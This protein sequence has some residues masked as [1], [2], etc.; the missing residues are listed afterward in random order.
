MRAEVLN[1][2][3]HHVNQYAEQKGQAHEH[4]SPVPCA[5]VAATAGPSVP[6]PRQAGEQSQ[7]RHAAS[8]P[9]RDFELN[10]RQLQMGAACFKSLFHRGQ[11]SPGSQW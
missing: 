1:G 4:Q 5:V 3:L 10:F 7:N 11:Q 9:R 6:P 2:E 8:Q